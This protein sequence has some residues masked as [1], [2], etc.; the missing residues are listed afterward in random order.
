[1][2]CVALALRNNCVVKIQYNGALTQQERQLLQ[3]IL[4]RNQLFDI[5]IEHSLNIKE[6]F[7]RRLALNKH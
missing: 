5:S 1:M 7:K 4:T 6:Q 2:N 3:K